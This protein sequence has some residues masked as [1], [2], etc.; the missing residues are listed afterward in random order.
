MN[1][2]VEL[3]NYLSISPKKFGIYLFD[4][5]NLKNLYK[6]ELIVSENFYSNNPK[7]L[8][9]FL[10]QNIFKIE[11]LSGK[12]VENI[13][14]IIENEQIFELQMG[15]KK[16]N[17]NNFVTEE[18]LINS[19]QEAKD[20]FNE[21]YQNEKILHMVVS[22]YLING[23][24]YN[25]FEKNLVSD[26]LALEIKFKF[27]SKL[28]TNDLDR[29]LENYQIKVS[30]YIDAN[31][32]KKLFGNNIELSEVAH[33]IIRGYN[34]N[35]VELAQKHTKKLSFFEKFFQLFG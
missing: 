22:K 29:V 21:N 35:E 23:K 13:F 2:E 34:E 17:Y 15:I 11:K 25:F 26:S 30:K 1:K 14:I 6:D 9:K 12:F 7:I 27:I 32:L 31:Y 16:K 8:K 18:T 10:D 3:E 28:M 5:K 24:K 4:K 19:L 20:L 33:R